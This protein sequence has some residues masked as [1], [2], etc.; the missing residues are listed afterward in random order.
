M[1]S[2]PENIAAFTVLSGGFLSVIQDSG[3]FGC[4][5]LGISSA[6]A[7]DSAS[8]RLGNLLVG[9]SS[10]APALEMT[11]VGG[12]FRV[13]SGC[14]VALTGSNFAPTLDGRPAPLWQSFE[15]RPGQ[16]LVF[17]A[18]RNGARCYLCVEGG[19]VV[20]P[21]FGSASTHVLTH[22]GGF[23]GR[24]LRPADVL[25]I[26]PHH[27]SVPSV[28][29]IVRTEILERLFLP[30]PLRV[31]DGPQISNFSEDMRSTF[32]SSD[33]VVKEDSNRMGLRLDG[34]AITHAD[35]GELITEGASVG[36]IQIPPDGYPILLFVEHPT[37]GGYA[38]IASVVSADFHRV[39]Q[40]RPRD[41]VRFEHV[42]HETALALLSEREVL[43]QQ[44]RCIQTARGTP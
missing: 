22:L 7:A 31:T 26:A 19:I 11:L 21:V 12:S 1:E 34:P 24:G 14:I 42:T 44:Q 13:E 15:L 6:G 8:Y 27:P 32:F 16:T 20:P 37:T 23:C 17:G 25:N 5:H 3:R 38:K 4:A 43:L 41:V 2:V 39:G 35:G 10:D 40:L 29:R 9:N 30:G 18:T 28:S 33:F 36:T